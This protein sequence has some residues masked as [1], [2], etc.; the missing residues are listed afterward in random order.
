MLWKK[1][2]WSWKSGFIAISFMLM[3]GAS[4]C[5]DIPLKETQVDETIVEIQ[6][7]S[8]NS[9]E[10]AEEIIDICLDFYKKAAEENKLADL[11]LIRREQRWNNNTHR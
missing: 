3:L 8:E 7:S 5:S 2:G 4:G 9:R 6:T 10:D 11:D 1:T